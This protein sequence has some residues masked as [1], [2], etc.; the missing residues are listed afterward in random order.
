M[1]REPSS[2]NLVAALA[3]D[4]GLRRETSRSY[5]AAAR[6]SRRVRLLRRLLPLLAILLVAAVALG[7]WL[8]P[9]RLIR[10]LPLEFAR[11]AISGTT[12]KIDAPKLTGYTRDGRGYSVSAASAAQD[13][14]QP[15]IIELTGIAAKFEL[16]GGGTTEL[17]AA[18]G[19]LEARAERMLLTEG[20]DIRS[21]TGFGGKLSEAI[22]DMRKG[23]VL[24]PS[25]VELHYQGGWIRA[26][27]LEIFE[28]GARAL[29]DGAVSASFYLAPPA[30]A[31]GP[32]P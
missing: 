19:R 3:A 9:L 14:G 1:G 4:P 29:F 13:I 17:T 12:L 23:H 25:P 8:D 21:S 11:M 5:R 31:T 2:S 10:E 22:I 30:A 16:A 7:A 20:I 28:N 18:K 24:S 27:R 26:N 6:H 15:G 32:T